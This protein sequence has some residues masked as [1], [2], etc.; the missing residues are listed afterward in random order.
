MKKKKIIIIAVILILIL[1]GFFAYKAYSQETN[2]NK[3][4]TTLSE[5]NPGLC[6]K[7]P[8]CI[9]EMDSEIIEREYYTLSYNE[10]HEQANWVMY[11][12]TKDHVTGSQLRDDKFK[13]DP[14][15]TTKSAIPADYKNSGY[16]RGHLCPAADMR[17]SKT[18]MRETFYL[19]NISPQKH[20]FN[21]G[22]WLDLEEDVR[23]FVMKHDSLYIV[24][25][26]VLSDTLDNY[27]GKTNHITVPDYFYKVI[28]SPKE[29]NMI[30]FLV[31]HI[32]TKNKAKTYVCEVD[33]IE[34]VT[35]LDFFTGVYNENQLES[36]ISDYN[37]WR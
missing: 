33:L 14:E 6:V 5:V 35:G 25:G 24:T 9:K 11:L 29:N 16:D 34:L 20:N 23:Q 22:V 17:I 30:G 31:P 4:L 3:P 7:Y 32:K 27:I 26:P 28:Y 19:S 1:L 36:Q 13:E 21:A 15:V 18:A 10:K 8:I 12:L 2:I 37:W